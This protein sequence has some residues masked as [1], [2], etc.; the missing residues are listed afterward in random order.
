MIHDTHPITVHINGRPV[1]A[2][3]AARYSLSDFIRERASLTGTHVGC[4]EGVCGSCTVLVNGASARSCLVLAV[5]VDGAQVTT[6]EGLSTPGE[7]SAVQTTLLEHS[8]FQCG[9]CTSGVVVLIEELLAEIDD[10]ARLTPEDIQDRLAGVICR[11]TGYAP[12]VAAATAC[13]ADRVK[14]MR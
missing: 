8:A 11:C 9:F 5:Q 7:L 1:C 10:G 14:G 13:I 12:I 6:I 2:A 4:G 3:V